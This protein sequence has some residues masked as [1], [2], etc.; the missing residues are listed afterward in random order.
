MA[1]SAFTIEVT[2]KTKRLLSQAGNGGYIPAMRRE[3]VKRGPLKLKL[4][5]IK[6]ML[7]GISPVKGVGKWPKYSAG[8]IKEIKKGKSSRMRRSKPKKRRSPVTLRLLGHLHH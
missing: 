5:I 2:G 7:K 6:S 3:W 8:Y 4:S 1:K